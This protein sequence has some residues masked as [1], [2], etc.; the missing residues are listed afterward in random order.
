MA[1]HQSKLSPQEAADR[2]VSVIGFGY[3]LCLDVKLSAC[4]AGP[5]GSRLIEL[6]GG[7]DRD[8][9]LPGE[10]VVRGVSSSI[11][12]DKGERTRFRSDV[13]SFTQMSEQIN[14]GLSLAG[15]IPCG[16]FNSMFGNTGSWQKDAASTKTLAFDGWFITLYSIELTRSHV[17]L[18][19]CVKHDVP[20]LWDPVALA[21]FIEKY[22]THVVVGLKMGGKDVISIKQL[23]KS[24]LQPDE[25]Q[26]LLKEWAD[27]K[28]ADPDGSPESSVT[29]REER[30]FPWEL[31]TAHTKSMRPLK[32]DDVT[33]NFVRRGGIESV[34]SHERWLSTVPQAP[35]VISM[36]FVPIT[37]LLSGL[38]GSGFLSH[39]INL[40]LRYKP[41]IEELSQFL[42]FQIP[43]QWAPMYGDLPLGLR[44]RK[45]SSPSLQFSLMSPRLFVNTTPVESGNRPV[46]GLRLYLEGKKSNHL[47][48]HLQHLS[49]LPKS[50]QLSEQHNHSTSDNLPE[51]GYFEPVNWSIFS[52]V[53][54]APV[55]H[56]GACFYD[57][58]RIVTKAWFEVKLV[59]MKKVLFLRL[60]FTTVTSAK[61]RRSEWDGPSNS[62]RRSGALSSMLMSTPFSAA[63]MAPPPEKPSKVEL[64]SAVFPGGPPNASKTAR[65]MG[66]VDTKE[67]VRG[68]EDAPGCWVVNGAKLAVEGGRICIKGKYC[69]LTF[70]A[71]ED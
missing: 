50:F 21:G 56:N 69:L 66:F 34:Q 8:L 46:T 30:T 40:Y 15:K 53:C 44:R 14:Q 57:D 48:I 65:M 62:S 54:T 58:A 42:E 51:R 23:Q 60:G 12:C 35:D 27:E 64:N 37:S 41:Q 70:M 16:M 49:T 9:V 22:G 10:V 5:D 36:S 71:E 3:D 25:V 59:G 39:A 20:A 1:G 61:I 13:L 67:M 31:S 7:Q 26:S 29:P 6:D 52:H 55:E 4:K 28:F 33:R 11:K 38:R 63:L 47:A 17:S 43:R 19:E 32:R 45:I 24:A 2:A 68:P 18:A